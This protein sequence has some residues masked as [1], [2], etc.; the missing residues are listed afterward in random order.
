MYRKS[1]NVGVGDAGN[2]ATGHRK[3]LDQNQC[4]RYFCDETFSNFVA[5]FSV[6]G[7]RLA[8]LAFCDA[9]QP[10][11]LQLLRTSLRTSAR[12][13][14]QS[15]SSDAGFIRASAARFAISAAH[16]LSTSSSTSSRLASSSSASCARSSAS[17]R[18]ASSSSFVASLV[19]EIIV[20]SA[21]QLGAE[22]DF[23]PGSGRLFCK[24]SGGPKPLS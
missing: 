10:K 15:S 6:P 3:L 20:A 9:P 18:N 7:G 22:A 19:I 4:S 2:G 1:S 12:A 24:S 21:A 5:P 8:E 13:L 14:R 23:G 17:S 11:W 16:A